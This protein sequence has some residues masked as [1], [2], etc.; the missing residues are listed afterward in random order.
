[1]IGRCYQGIVE[2]GLFL[3]VSC[4]NY[5]LGSHELIQLDDFNGFIF[6]YFILHFIIF[7]ILIYFL[8]LFTIIII[9]VFKINL[10]FFLNFVLMFFINLL[11]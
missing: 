4:R 7:F 9:I 10:F 1:M 3:I 8:I 11:S 2:Q 6:I 5:F